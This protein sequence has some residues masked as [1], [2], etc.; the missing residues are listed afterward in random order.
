V[1]ETR[2]LDHD[3]GLV[4]S[5]LQL[6]LERLGEPDPDGI[7]QDPGFDG[8]VGVD[9]LDVDEDAGPAEDRG[10]KRRDA[11]LEGRRISRA[12]AGF[13]T[14]WRANSRRYGSL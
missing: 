9:V 11:Q 10:E 5:R 1:G 2:L 6:A 3:T 7:P 8:Q 14:T 4:E 12:L 13:G